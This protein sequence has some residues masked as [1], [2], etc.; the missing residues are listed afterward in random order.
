M[1][2]RR[3]PFDHTKIP[4]IMKKLVIAA[5]LA[6]LVSTVP[7]TARAAD[8]NAACTFSGWNTTFVW[9][10]GVSALDCYGAVDGNTDGASDRIRMLSE[11]E[12]EFDLNGASLV[13]NGWSEPAPYATFNSSN[14]TVTFSQF[15]SGK[16]AVALKQANQYSVYLLQA[17]TPVNSINYTSAGVKDGA[18]S[19][20]S[21][22]NMYL[23]EGG[24]NATCIGVNGCT[25]VVPEPSTYALMASG[26]LGIFGFA[27]RRRNNA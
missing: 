18:T 8:N 10:T 20:L 1:S 7:A 24:P 19:G 14:A 25:S 15:V 4:A 9:G 23:V 3:N 17:T 2:E 12:V 22:A 27:R 16:F 26:L 5:A 6:A 13:P 11:L 21:H